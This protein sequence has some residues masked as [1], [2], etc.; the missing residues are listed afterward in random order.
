MKVVNFVFPTTIVSVTAATGNEQE[1]V[2]LAAEA[3]TNDLGCSI[4]YIDRACQ[5]IT[6]D[7]NEWDG[8]LI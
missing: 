3:I 2:K 5:E 1:I 4:E 7:G 6:I 8:E